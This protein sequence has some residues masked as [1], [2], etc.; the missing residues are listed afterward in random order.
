MRY[1]QFS[2]KG[3]ARE[4][5][6]SGK[7]CAEVR[8]RSVAGKMKCNVWGLLSPLDSDERAPRPIG[9]DTHNK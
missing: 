4:H 3:R 1:K 8:G 9:Q 6:G 2:R 5:P 7:I